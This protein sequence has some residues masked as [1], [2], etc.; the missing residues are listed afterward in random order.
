[1]GDWALKRIRACWFNK[2]QRCFLH[3]IFD[4]PATNPPARGFK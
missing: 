4:S 2:S 3:S 1:M